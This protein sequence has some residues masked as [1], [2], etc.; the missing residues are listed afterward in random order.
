MSSCG[1]SI[2]RTSRSRRASRRGRAPRSAISTPSS[3][4]CARAFAKAAS[5]ELATAEDE[6]SAARRGASQVGAAAPAPAAA[7]AGRRRGPA[8]RRPYRRRS[9]PAGRAADD[10]RPSGSEIAV[11]AQILN[12]D[13]GFVREGQR[14]PGQAGGLPLHRL[15]PGRG[16]GRDDQPRRH[17]GREDRPRLRRP[18][19]PR[20]QLHLRSAAAA[21]RSARAWRSRPR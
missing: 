21:S 2:C 18:G 5:T 10:H 1:S 14:G 19:P 8:A 3:P 15:R 17:P 11:E 13:I 16:H 12:K 20:P 6:S 9:G 7:L 4:S